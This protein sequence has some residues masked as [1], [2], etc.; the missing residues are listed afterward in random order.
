MVSGILLA[1]V[2]LLAISV[3][4]SYIILSPEEE[5]P[6]IERPS[7]IDFSLKQEGANILIQNT[8]INNISARSLGIYLGNTL[9]QV[10]NK[11]DI[12]PASAYTIK[13]SELPSFEGKVNITVALGNVN[14]SLQV[15]SIKEVTAPVS[16]IFPPLPKPVPQPVPVVRIYFL[17][18]GIIGGGKVTFYPN[19]T[20]FEEGTEVEINAIPDVNHTFGYWFFDDIT[21]SNSSQIVKMD[22]NHS[23]TAVF[24]LRSDVDCARNNPSITIINKTPQ[25]NISMTYL[26]NTTNRDYKCGSESFELTFSCQPEFS[27]NLQDRLISIDSGNS[28]ATVDFFM[29]AKNVTA[30]SKGNYT[31]QITAKNRADTRYSSTNSSLYEIK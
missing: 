24:L 1:V 23:L 25:S 8:G 18:I 19:A 10:T 5:R 4:V 28:S 14:H 3:I 20:E 21:I 15:T 13:I 16:E 31:F 29:S 6:R 2:S 30:M 11:N 26:V 12:P 17:S 9:T 22:K 27:C 7:F